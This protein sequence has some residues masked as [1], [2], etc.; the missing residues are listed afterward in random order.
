M[1]WKVFIYRQIDS[2]IVRQIDKQIDRQI[3]RY[4]DVYKQID[5]YMIDRCMEGYVDKKIDR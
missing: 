4:I 3:D 5:T 1:Y 2:Y